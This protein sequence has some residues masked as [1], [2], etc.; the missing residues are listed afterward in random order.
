MPTHTTYDLRAYSSN[1]GHRRID[2]ALRQCATLYNAGLQERRDA[3]KM[4][5][6]SL[7]MYDQMR[8][9]TGVRADDPEWSAL[10][11]QIGRGVLHRLDKAFNAFFRRVKAGAT[12]GFPRFKS[13]RR[14]RTLEIAEPRPC[15]VKDKGNGR[16]QVKIKGLPTLT[17]KIGRE[18]PPSEQLKTL[19]IVKKGRRLFVNLGYAVE[20]EPLPVNGQAVGLDMGVSSRIASSDGEHVAGV[21]RDRREVARLQRRVSRAR[22]GSKGRQRKV[23]QLA[24]ASERN[25]VSNRNECHRITTDIVRRYGFIAVE[26]LTIPNMTASAS[27]T[28]E[29]PGTNVAAKSGL[30]REILSQTWGLIREQL[31]YKAAWAGRQFVEVNPRYTSRECSRCGT[32]GDGKTPGRV[33]RCETCGLSIDRDENAAINVLRRGL[34][35]A[36]GSP[37]LSAT[38][39]VGRHQPALL[40]VCA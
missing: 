14:W 20:K 21:K 34:S 6:H 22:K 19:R 2:A 4:A 3:Y 25:R 33:F 27:G 10:D 26:K 37:V 29:E 13:G 7:T 28:A 38:R 36:S 9:F 32:L 17:V 39:T 1:A 11:A 30:N 40:P 35:A 16:W 24:R 15:M 8:Q 12:P 23:A 31:R 5:G 18:L